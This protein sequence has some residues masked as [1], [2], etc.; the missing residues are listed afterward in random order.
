M[1][2]KAGVDFMQPIE[3]NLTW[4]TYESFRIAFLS[5]QEAA[6]TGYTAFVKVTDT[7]Q[8]W[9]ADIDRYLE[10]LNARYCAGL[11]LFDIRNTPKDAADDD[12]V[13]LYCKYRRFWLKGLK[14]MSEVEVRPLTKYFDSVASGV[15]NA[16]V[17]V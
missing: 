10:V 13:A 6:E 17:T 4:Y 15:Q 5:A 8:F 11:V 1:V 7:R 14:A 9:A 3:L 12:F 16:S 2:W